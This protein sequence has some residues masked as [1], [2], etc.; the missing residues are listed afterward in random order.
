[1]ALEVPSVDAVNA[2]SPY[3][4][5]PAPVDGTAGIDAYT[6]KLQ[7]LLDRVG[8]SPG[9]IDGIPGDNVSKAVAS[10]DR[11]YGQVDDGQ[12]DPL[13]FD[14]LEAS[15]PWPVLV[16][17]QITAEDL[18]GPFLPIPEDY[19]EKAQMARQGFSTPLEMFG[20]RFHMDEDLLVALNP[21]VD[22]GVSGTAIVVAD[23]GADTGGLEIS[24][25]EVDKTAG[26]LRG[27]DGANRLVIAYPA[28]VGSEG[29]ESPHGTHKVEGVA[30]DPIYYYNPDVNFR[31]GENT[32]KLQI[33]PGPNNPVGVVWID[34]DAP[35]YGI[36]GTPEPAHINKTTSHGCVRLTNWDV[37]ELSAMVKPGIEV[38]FVD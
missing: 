22:F 4:T 33:P 17:Y 1:M 18:V 35:T 6:L 24:R 21:G 25:I 11:I 13:E 12:I 10:F 28:S 8:I 20:E 16:T 2:A 29:T 32:Q 26:E 31:Q 14:G 38:A 3:A 5:Y 19:A 27:Y 15:A 37:T 34:L 36:H 23:I 7:V 9:V 30:P